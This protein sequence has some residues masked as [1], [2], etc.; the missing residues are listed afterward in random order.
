MRAFILT[1]SLVALWPTH[2]AAL[3]HASADGWYTWRV[4]A[5]DD[6]PSW[7]CVGWNSGQSTP[8]ACQ[9]DSRNH[10]FSHTDDYLPETSEVQVYAR[11]VN[12][13]ADRIRA[14]S[15]ACPVETSKPLND[16]GV[17]SAADSLDWLK[18]YARNDHDSNALPAIS[19]HRGTEALNVVRELA[20]RDPSKDMREHAIF[21]LGQ[22]RIADGKE[23]L[24]Q[25]MFDDPS[26][27][28][29]EH[30][31]FSLSQSSAADKTA[32]LI[33]QGRTDSSAEVRGRAWFWLAQTGAAESEAAILQAMQDDRSKEVRESAVFALS[34][35]PDERGIASLVR[36]VKDKTM[37]RRLREQA[38]FWLAESGNDE[39]FALIDRL[40][41]AR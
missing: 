38:L 3:P 10:G 29:R 40:L 16:L 18:P 36:M 31:A 27:E 20:L 41:S 28:F 34:Q 5:V 25:I 19:L 30:A 24:V 2:A 9:L 14:L 4:A 11:L 7:C 26:T 8:G 17:V 39:A 15:P 35:L 1:C 23:T 33:R 6:A 21:W 12:G 37:D 22:V 13:K 32:L